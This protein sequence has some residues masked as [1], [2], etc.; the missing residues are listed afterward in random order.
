VT[1]GYD[2][3]QRGMSADIIHSDASRLSFATL[4]QHA[5][6]RAGTSAVVDSQ[7]SED[8]DAWLNVDADDFDDMLAKTMGTG[9]ASQKPAPT[10][11]AMDVDTVGSAAEDEM[12]D[13]QAARLRELAQK[14]SQF[15]EGKGTVEGATFAEC[16]FFGWVARSTASSRV[17]AARARTPMTTRGRTAR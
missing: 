17:L 5:V 8:S 7:E 1:S 2:A 10:S 9:G 6:A 15:V 16:V 11:D 13:T 14:V 3:I 4:V 12:A